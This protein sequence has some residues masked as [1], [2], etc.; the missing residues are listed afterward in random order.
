MAATQRRQLTAPNSK[1]TKI[2]LVALLRKDEAWILLPAEVRQ[3]LYSLLPLPREGEAPHDPDVHPLNTAYKQHIEKEIRRF[4]DDLK[5]G[6]EQKKWRDEAM[7]AGRDRMEGKFDEWKQL[8]REAYWG[9]EN[10]ENVKREENY[11][12]GEGQSGADLES[13]KTAE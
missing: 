2:N 4:K 11:V 1:L 5:E 8:E 13:G 6:R 10:D 9:A 7:Q 12:N 3:Q